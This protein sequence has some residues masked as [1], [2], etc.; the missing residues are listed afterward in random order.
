[1]AIPESGIYA[2]KRHIWRKNH[3][4]GRCGQISGIEMQRRFAAAWPLERKGALLLAA[5]R[6]ECWT[7][8]CF[9]AIVT[10][11]EKNDSTEGPAVCL[12]QS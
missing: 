11:I 10:I 12:P 4:N 6:P 3:P 9:G 1:M 5:S 7:N 8:P 2:K